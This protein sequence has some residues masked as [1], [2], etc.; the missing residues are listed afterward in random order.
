MKSLALTTFFST[1]LLSSCVTSPLGR[2]QVAFLPDEQMSQMGIQAFGELKQKTP[3]ETSP[4][5]NTYVNC[6]ASAITKETGGQWEVVVFKDDSANAF[7]LPGSKIGVHTGI[8][9]VAQ[10][11]SQLA[12]VIG[13]EIA[14]VLSKHGNERASQEMLVNEGLS[15]TKGLLGT[16]GSDPMVS[17][18]LGLGAK[19]GILLPYSRTHESEADLYGLDLM[20]KAGFDPRE[21]VQLWENMSKA[22]GNKSSPNFL[23]T[24]PSHETRIQELQNRI[25]SS[26]NL[27]NQ[28]KAAGKNPSCKL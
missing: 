2:S 5:I 4:Q 9:K 22:S 15:L 10:T 24:H 11:P 19:V 12:A 23:S 28:A 26:L 3:I 18:A 17:A 20:A 16:K 14:H 8:L 1:V 27:Y 13:H 25:P 21:S 6:I 7:A